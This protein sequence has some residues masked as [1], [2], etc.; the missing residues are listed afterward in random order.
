MTLTDSSDGLTTTLHLL[1]QFANQFAVNKNDYS[2]TSDMLGSTPG[3]I[4]SVDHTLG[5]PNHG[6]GHG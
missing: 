4:F 3:T 6:I 2:L 1:N 5:T